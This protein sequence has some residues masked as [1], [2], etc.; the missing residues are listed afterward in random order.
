[1]L[2][3]HTVITATPRGRCRVARADPQQ[4]LGV[5]GLQVEG[6]ILWGGVEDRQLQRRH[7]MKRAWCR[8]GVWWFSWSH[9]EFNNYIF[10]INYQYRTNASFAQQTLV[11]WF[12]SQCE[13][14]IL[15]LNIACWDLW[16]SCDVLPAGCRVRPEVDQQTTVAPPA[17][18]HCAPHRAAWWGR[19]LPPA[20]LPRRPPPGP[21]GQAAGPRHPLSGPCCWSRT[22]LIG[23]E[24]RQVVPTLNVGAIGS[25]GGRRG[26]HRAAGRLYRHGKP[27]DPP[28]VLV[29]G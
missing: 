17:E 12:I 26:Q 4:Q 10:L 11:C 7:H 19:R 24:Q 2:E 29:P 5:V 16:S 6:A 20:S 18:S 1:M 23:W 27:T 21:G 28:G 9:L 3:S 15:N 13:Q 14:N 8:G 25:G 22:T